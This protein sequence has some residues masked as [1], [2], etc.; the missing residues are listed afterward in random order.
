MS[1]SRSSSTLQ[2]TTIPSRSKLFFKVSGKESARPVQPYISIHQE[3]V[4]YPTKQTAPMDHQSCTTTPHPRTWTASPIK[5]RTGPST[6][7]FVIFQGKKRSSTMRESE[8]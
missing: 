5:H 8:S 4:S 7:F 6:S 2:E 1:A 3:A